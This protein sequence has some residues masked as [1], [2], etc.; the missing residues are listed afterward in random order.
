M[1]QVLRLP[2][3]RGPEELSFFEEGIRRHDTAAMDL[4]GPVEALY[5]RL[6]ALAL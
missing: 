1:L 4:P 2:D 3:P 5:R 6:Q